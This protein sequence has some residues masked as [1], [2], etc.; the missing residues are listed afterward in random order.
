MMFTL[1][2][3]G[4][5]ND[6]G[7]SEDQHSHSNGE[8]SHSHGEHDHAEHSSSEH[9]H[10]G[11][12]HPGTEGEEPGDEIAL[13]ATIDE[14][15]HGARLILSYDSQSNSF[16]GTVENTTAKTLE[17]VRVEV[18]LSN[19]KGLGPTMPMDLE[20]GKKMD[21]Q[22]FAGS[23]AFTGW[24]AHAEVGSDEHSHEH[25]EGEHSHSHE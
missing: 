10:D 1:F 20:P 2:I 4:C 25:G 8:H 19:G 3:W 17:K 13:D 23:N 9:D 16:N 14:V 24:S 22:L 7:T 18:Y 11:H 6:T 21:V 5:P 12:E 15:C